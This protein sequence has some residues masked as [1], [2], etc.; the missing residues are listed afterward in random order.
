MP[1]KVEPEGEGDDESEF[2][3]SDSEYYNTAS[4]TASE[5]TVEAAISSTNG[6]I[7]LKVGENGDLETLEAG[8]A[9]EN[10]DQENNVADEEQDE[11]SA[12]KT[13]AC[14][15]VCCYKCRK[16]GRKVRRRIKRFWRQCWPLRKVRKAWRRFK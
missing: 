15:T 6:D 4:D 10:L 9:A 14:C 5:A 1:N 13:C 3:T 7:A 11:A 8:S 12:K 16:G 2:E